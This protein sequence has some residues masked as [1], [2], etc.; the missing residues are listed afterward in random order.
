MGVPRFPVYAKFEL[1][2]CGIIH[3]SYIKVK[4][5]DPAVLSPTQQDQQRLQPMARLAIPALLRI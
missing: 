4:K 2:H 3:G 1:H 5:I